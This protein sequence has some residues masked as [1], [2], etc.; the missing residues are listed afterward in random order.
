MASPRRLRS[1]SKLIAAVTSSEPPAALPPSVPPSVPIF[2]AT[3]GPSNKPRNSSPTRVRLIPPG[4]SHL[5]GLQPSE[6]A[7]LRA[8]QRK[9]STNASSTLKSVPNSIQRNAL[10]ATLIFAQY[11]AG[12]AVSI[13]RSGWVLTCAHCFGDTEEEYQQSS[14]RRWLLFYTGLAVQVECR[15][16]DLTRDLALL[17]IIAVECDG[18][19]VPAFQFLLPAA[20]APAKGT[21]VVCIGQP[22]QDDLES[23]SARRT[24]YHLIEISEG[25][26]RGMVPGA[27]PQDN[28]EIGTLKHDAWTY[29]GHSGAPLIDAE[30]GTLI[31]LHSSWDDQT[32][33][34][35]G[36]PHAA[37][38]AFLDI[39]LNV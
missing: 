5:P 33:M 30:D 20:S 8:K 1:A 28:A 36:V 25:V 23:T 22:G 4:A 26:F 15:A 11:E 31:G 12:S 29:W 2:R 7:L 35:H 18:A 6:L 14:K 38:K 34:R 3:A 10:E 16:W 39:H 17:R 37:I 27:D 9:L 32:A 13:D 19:E 21:R 24:K